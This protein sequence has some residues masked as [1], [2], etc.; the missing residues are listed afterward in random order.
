MR[1]RRPLA[2][3]FSGH[4]DAV[5]ALLLDSDK[6]A[7]TK[8]DSSFLLYCISSSSLSWFVSV[9]KRHSNAFSYRGLR[10]LFLWMYL[11][12]IAFVSAYMCACVLSGSLC[13][14]ACLCVLLGTSEAS[15][16]LCASAYVCAW[17]LQVVSGSK[18]SS[19]RVWDLRTGRPRLVCAQH[20]GGVQCLAL[21]PS[22]D[23]GRG[24]YYSGA[25]DATVQVR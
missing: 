15:A 11:R 16:N 1:A 2:F 12:L 20:F 25:R 4:T 17:S 22:A 10:G 23:G 9:K 6:S 13:V 14:F 5:T 8:R 3:K 24:A 18:D 19:V 7:V 21:D